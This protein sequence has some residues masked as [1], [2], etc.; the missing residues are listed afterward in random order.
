MCQSKPLVPALNLE[1]VSGEQQQQPPDNKITADEN[2]I[3]TPKGIL[4]YRC[5]LAE[6]EDITNGNNGNKDSG[7]GKEP[8]SESSDEEGNKDPGDGKEPC[9]E[10]SNNV[11]EATNKENSSD[12]KTKQANRKKV[13]LFAPLLRLIGKGGVHTKKKEGLIHQNKEPFNSPYI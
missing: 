1:V 2:I 11:K 7:N 3:V 12:A 8:C 13:G 6:V 4:T 9:S 5:Y 10:R